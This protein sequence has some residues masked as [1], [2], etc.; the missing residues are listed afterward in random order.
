[1]TGGIFAM[2]NSCVNPLIYWATNKEYR[3]RTPDRDELF[4]LFKFANRKWSARNSY[5][6]EYQ[7]NF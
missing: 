6:L 1:M 2:F 5:D 7:L 4:E 3:D